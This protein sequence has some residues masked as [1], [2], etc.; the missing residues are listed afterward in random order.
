MKRR[1]PLSLQS[2]HCTATDH[3]STAYRPIH[4]VH[5]S[6]FG[7]TSTNPAPPARAASAASM[8]RSWA[9]REKT[10][11]LCWRGVLWNQP[12]ADRTPNLPGQPGRGTRLQDQ[13]LHRRHCIQGVRWRRPCAIAHRG[14]GNGECQWS[15]QLR[16]LHHW[17]WRRLRAP[18]ANQALAWSARRFRYP[19]PSTAPTGIPYR[20]DEQS[21]SHRSRCTSGFFAFQHTNNGTF[22][23]CS[24]PHSQH[25]MCKP[26][27]S[28]PLNASNAPMKVAAS[29][30]HHDEKKNITTALVPAVRR[31]QYPR[32]P[33]RRPRHTGRPSVYHLS[34]CHGRSSSQPPGFIPI[35]YQP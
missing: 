3:Q 27:P 23:A 17:R 35:S 18:M 26:R 25:R 28:S 22:R 15:R 6:I 29:I 24:I 8:C 13:F 10:R 19:R 21:T 16:P 9:A 32:R 20:I 33:L 4:T 2:V 5:L 14:L 30:A 7:T 31:P 11:R 34:A 12:P 1:P